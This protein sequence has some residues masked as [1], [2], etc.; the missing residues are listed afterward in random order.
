VTGVDFDIGVMEEF[1]R[2]DPEVWQ[3]VVVPILG[4]NN[5]SILAISTPLGE[6]NWYTSLLTRKNETGDA[7]FNVKQ[8]TL[9]CDDCKKAGVS[10]NC[11]HR[12]DLLPPWK[13][14]TRQKLVKFL[15]NDSTNMYLSEAMGEIAGIF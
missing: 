9:V 15:L 8:F 6:D 4:V 1:T 5:T 11:Q 13:S 7:L 3:E 2:C 10:E 12:M 14:Q